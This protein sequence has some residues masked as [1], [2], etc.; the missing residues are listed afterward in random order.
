[1]SD[2]SIDE[3]VTWSSVEVVALIN[4]TLVVGR[5]EADIGDTA[6]I[7]ASPQFAGW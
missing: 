6:D 2:H 4:S 1:M 7:L 5:N 3:D